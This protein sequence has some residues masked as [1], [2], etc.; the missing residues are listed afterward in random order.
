MGAIFYIN[1]VAANSANVG[2]TEVFDVPGFN[3]VWLTQYQNGVLQFDGPYS[4]PASPY[5]FLSRDA[6]V[7]SGQVY[8][9]SGGQKGS[10]IDSFSFTVNGTAT[11]P[12]AP[13]QPVANA[14][15][16]Q[17]LTG[18][19]SPSGSP[20]NSVVQT[21]SSGPTGTSVIPQGGGSPVYVA[22]NPTPTGSVNSGTGA[23]SPSSGSLGGVAAA[24]A[25]APGGGS[26]TSTTSTTST[27]DIVG[28]F[29]SHLFWIV[30]AGL[31]LVFILKKKGG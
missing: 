1:G 26:S 22:P 24:T 20:G 18:L 17:C 9:L 16:Q 21:G 10:L 6:G 7:F 28:F 8:Q 12:T 15:Q 31:I 29:K 25:P 5:T 11:A 23:P 14:P 13:N 30:V 27:F 4:V 19:C 3:Q 2:D